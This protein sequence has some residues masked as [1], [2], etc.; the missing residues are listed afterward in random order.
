M[1]KQRVVSYGSWKSP[2][3][4][5]MAASVTQLTEVAIQWRFDLLEGAPSRAARTLHSS[6]ADR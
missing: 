3:T 1:S 5:E 6:E 2:I 4:P